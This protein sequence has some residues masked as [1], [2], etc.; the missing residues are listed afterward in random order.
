MFSLPYNALPQDA[1]MWAMMPLLVYGFDQAHDQVW[2]ADRARLPLTTSLAELAAARGRVKNNKYRL[3]QLDP[4][5]A[6]KLPG[7][8]RK[9]IWDCIQLFTEAPPKGS[10]NNFGLQA[11]RWWGELLLK[12]KARLSWE[13]EF[14][15]GVK[16]YA[17]LTN[18]YSDIQHFGKDSP[19]E[20]EVYADFLA[21]ASLLLE[22]PGM[23]EAAALYRS[24]ALAWQALALALLPDQVAAFQEAR[25]LMDRRHRLFLNQGGAG[26]GEMR[27][28]DA[29]LAEIR[30]SMAD[31]F[32]LDG[33]GVVE[34]RQRIAEQ[35]MRVHDIEKQAI[36]A[37]EAAIK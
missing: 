5:E 37:L 32:P 10:R 20:R 35:V 31:D 25:L 36:E 16:L 9:G 18:A 24:S 17:A 6:G 27:R 34:L 30:L 13:R 12:P 15:A 22:K 1:G 7:A 4:P 21:E 28:I 26:L 11:Y 14:P 8:A 19:A 23:N 33:Q 3:L 29:R 2:I